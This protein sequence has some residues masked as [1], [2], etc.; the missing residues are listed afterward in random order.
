M[1]NI[2]LVCAC[3]CACAYVY[4]EQTQASDQRKNKYNYAK[5]SL[6][7]KKKIFFKNIQLIS[8][9]TIFLMKEK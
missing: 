4:K 1:S 3:A 6:L 7:Y 9:V 5:Q 8:V 2:N